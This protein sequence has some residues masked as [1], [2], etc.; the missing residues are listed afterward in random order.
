M[1]KRLN[2][3]SE[4]LKYIMVLMSG[5][6]AAQL[7]GYLFAPVIT[8][9]YTPEEGA[10][11][12]LFLRIIGVGAALATVRYEHALPILKHDAHSYRLYRFSFFATILVTF[13]SILILIVPA[14]LNPTSS[15]TLFYGLVPVG[16]F[17]TAMYNLGT[18]WSI[19]MKK[20]RYITFARVTNSLIGNSAKVLFGVMQVGYL[21]LIAGT[22]IGL[23]TANIW[24]IRDFF[25]TNR[26]FQVPYRSVRNW[27]L[28]KE[29]KEFPT[30]N[31]PHAIMD[32]SRDLLMA[33][34]ILEL[35]SKE[36]FGLYDHSYRMLRLP[37]VFIGVAIGQ[38]FFQR[39]AEKINR[40]EDIVGM[41]I[42]VT[43]NLALL[44][45]VPFTILFFYGEE[46]FAFV[47][48]EEW[49]S[50]GTY[51]E[52]LSPMFMVNFISSP[53]STLPLVLRKQRAFFVLSI[54]ASVLMLVTLTVPPMFLEW[55]IEQTLWLF[56]S[57]QLVYLLFVVWRIFTFARTFQHQK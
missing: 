40:G 6:V 23:V 38:V 33:V 54:V 12:G 46:L 44:A 55:K 27:I 7:L 57:T 56:G 18:N 16:L 3:K 24:F 39:S 53:I 49:R 41:M 5:T 45:I 4:F 43:K 29:Y 8:R 9:L 22:V 26:T 31:L 11:L 48:G 36:D 35:F 52:I 25:K 51:A 28:A 21:G 37:L 2:L 1:L 30:I 19:R 42:K 13:V 20:F 10:E 14:V 15:N 17:F 34:L 47:F 32:L 50:A